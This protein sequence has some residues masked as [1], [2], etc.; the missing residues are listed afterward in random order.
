MVFLGE[1]VFSAQPDILN[2]DQLSHS[3]PDSIAAVVERVI[4]RLQATGDLLA[5]CDKHYN[6]GGASHMI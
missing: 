2:Q 1:G 3:N 6:Q 5:P 4:F